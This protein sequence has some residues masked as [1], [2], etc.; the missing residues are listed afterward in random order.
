MKMLR[1]KMPNNYRGGVAMGRVN[2][3]LLASLLT[4]SAC[5]FKWPQPKSDLHAV[6]DG[7]LTLGVVASEDEEGLQAYRLLLCKKFTAYNAL[8]GFFVSLA[9]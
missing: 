6:T 8:R 4:T 1:G 3:L 7:K 5:V 9:S 2:L